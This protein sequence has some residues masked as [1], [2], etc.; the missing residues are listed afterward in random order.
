MICPD[1]GRTLPNTDRTCSTCSAPVATGSPAVQVNQQIGAVESGGTVI[2]AQVDQRR[3]ISG[4]TFYGLTIG[5][6]EGGT[7]NCYAPPSAIDLHAA[8]DRLAALP[9]DRVPPIAP[10]PDPSRIIYIYEQTLCR[11]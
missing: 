6:M 11:S 9:L 2:G 8:N 3:G 4:G 1:C 5:Y 10:L 7:V